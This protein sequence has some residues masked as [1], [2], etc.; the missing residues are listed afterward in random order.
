MFGSLPL[1]VQF[2]GDGQWHV[3]EA[4]LLPVNRDHVVPA[5]TIQHLS[6]FVPGSYVDPPV[7]PLRLNRIA[8]Q[9]LEVAKNTLPALLDIL[10]GGS[11]E[12]FDRLFSA[13]MGG[14]GLRCQIFRLLD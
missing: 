1:Q 8:I 11:G 6:L 13:L 14:L 12:L 9:L 4:A 2:I 3:A 10:V 7:A 5:G